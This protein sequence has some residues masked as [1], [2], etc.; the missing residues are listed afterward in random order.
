M[1]GKIILT[2]YA[3]F[4]KRCKG[5]PTK[6]FEIEFQKNKIKTQQSCNVY[7]LSSKPWSWGEPKK[8]IKKIKRVGITIKMGWKGWVCRGPTKVIC[9]RME[10]F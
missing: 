9:A 4:L 3:L 7:C 1:G 5:T 10:G 6:F 8:K 2:F